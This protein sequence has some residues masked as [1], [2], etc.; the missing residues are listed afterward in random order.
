MRLI[1]ATLGRIWSG[2]RRIPKCFPRGRHSLA[3][4]RIRHRSVNLRQL[5]L[6]SKTECVA[7]K[8]V[9]FFEGPFLTWPVEDSPHY[10][11]KRIIHVSTVTFWR[12]LNASSIWMSNLINTYSYFELLDRRRCRKSPVFSVFFAFTFR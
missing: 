2:T 4:Q 7:M 5:F 8:T 9:L 11:P 3:P 10:L 6:F 12:I 1:T